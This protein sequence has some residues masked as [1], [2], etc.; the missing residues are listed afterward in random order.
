MAKRLL[1]IESIKIGDIEADGGMSTSLAALGTTY[2]GTCQM[3]K[4]EAEETP[5][6][7]EENDDPEEII[8]KKGVTTFVWGISD[9]TPDVI[10]KVFGGTVT[11]TG[12]APDE[13][14]TWN[15]PDSAPKIEQS[16]EIKSKSGVTIAAPRVRITA[17]VD[18][19]I[20]KGKSSVIT[21]KATVMKPTKADTPS[22]S[23][24]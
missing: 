16:L 14:D 15:E 3:T 11:T 18:D 23:I 8:T 7:C 2:E 9:W 19:N 6:F 5:E 17:S 1:S 13:V 10:V 21:V 12:V 22:M 24:T 20:G 4:P